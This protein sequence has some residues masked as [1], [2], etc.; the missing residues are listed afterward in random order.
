M[1]KVGLSQQILEEYLPQIPKR[2]YFISSVFVLC[3]IKPECVYVNINLE[4]VGYVNIYCNYI[5]H[6]LW[7]IQLSFMLF[8]TVSL[9][10]I[11]SWIL[12]LNLTWK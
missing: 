4:T 5:E 9:V 1:Y 6:V 10:R 3:L 8:Q 7:M 12:N 2:C 11:E